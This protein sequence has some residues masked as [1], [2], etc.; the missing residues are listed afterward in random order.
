MIAYAAI[1]LRGGRV[2]QLIGGRP[3]QTRLSLPDP[4]QV[5]RRWVEAGFRALHLIDLDAALGDGSNRKQ[6]ERIIAGARVPVQVGGGVRDARTVAALLQTGA[7]R[8]IVGT[9]ALA[10]HDW[11]LA[12]AERHRGRV[13]VAVDVRGD[14]VVSDGWRSTTGLRPLNQLSALETV[15]LAGIL[16]T[17]VDREGRLDGVDADRFAA[18]VRDTR[19][20]LIAA[21]G[22]TSIRDLRALQ[23]SGVAGAV[24][25]TALYTGAVEADRVAREFSS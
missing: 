2:V 18:L 15:P 1:D 25:G 8:V 7:S 12:L 20:P 21:G 23:S 11:V 17:D 3:Q 4:P 22:I 19:H 5:A 16:V 14:E 9:R 6:V 24:I 13:V 10:D